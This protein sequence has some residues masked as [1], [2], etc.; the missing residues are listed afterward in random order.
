[1]P[2]NTGQRPVPGWKVDRMRQKYID[3]FYHMAPEEQEDAVKS[4]PYYKVIYK[5]GEIKPIAEKQ[6]HANNKQ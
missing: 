4:H 2:Y 1:M 3:R 6:I 5:A